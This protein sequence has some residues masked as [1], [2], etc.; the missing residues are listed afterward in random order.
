MSLPSNGAQPQTEEKHMKKCFSGK[1]AAAL[2]LAASIGLGADKY[3]H[4]QM[5]QLSAEYTQWRDHVHPNTSEQ[6]Y[7]KIPWRASVLQA[8]LMLRKQTISCRC[9]SRAEHGHRKCTTAYTAKENG[10]PGGLAFR[11]PKRGE[12]MPGLRGTAFTI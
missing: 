3:Q 1:I 2:L 6:S 11:N 5:P 10:T 9:P 7:R 8:S 12:S 4:L